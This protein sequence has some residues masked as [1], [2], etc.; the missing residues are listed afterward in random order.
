MSTFAYVFLVFGLFFCKIIEAN[1]FSAG[2]MRQSCSNQMESLGEKKIS[3]EIK[4]NSLLSTKKIGYIH[5]KVQASNKSSDSPIEKD[6]LLFLGPNIDR[7]N[8]HMFCHTKSIDYTKDMRFIK[9]A[10]RK[11]RSK[12]KGGREKERKKASI[13]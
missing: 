2:L 4:A 1:T 10:R 13:S 3:A 9:S 5:R 11:G 6:P 8:L 7:V 12:G